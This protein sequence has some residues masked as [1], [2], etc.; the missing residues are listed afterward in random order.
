MSATVGAVIASMNVANSIAA[1]FGLIET[2]SSNVSSL[3]H[4]SFKSARLHLEMARTASSR[5]QSKE[6]I[7]EAMKKFVEAIAVEKDENLVSS[8]VGLAMCQYLL[9]DK[10]NAQKAIQSINNVGL[11]KPQVMKAGAKS[12]LKKYGFLPIGIV[13]HIVGWNAA[14][15][16]MKERKLDFN[17]YKYKALLE[18]NNIN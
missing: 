14:N 1:Y 13:G 17:D 15:K 2:V 9:G 10:E 11:S 5:E 3:V 12:F 8:Y 4:Q 16:G 6:Y 18:M 7:K